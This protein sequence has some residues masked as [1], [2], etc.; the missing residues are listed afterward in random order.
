MNPNT[1]FLSN[2]KN[3]WILTWLLL[4]TFSRLLPH[5]P[6]FT[7]VL[8]IALFCGVEIANKKIALMIPLIIMLI[9]DLYTW[10]SQILPQS[11]SDLFQKMLGINF[12]V[13]GS[14]TLINFIGARISKTRTIASLFIATLISSI[15]FFV[16]TNLAS[17]I[18]F[19]PWTGEGLILCFTNA[20]PYYQNT[21]LSTLLYSGVF[22]G[23]LSWVES[24][25]SP[26]W[27]IHSTA[28]RI[29]NQIGSTK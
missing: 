6:N 28:I 18:A 9:G 21:L 8:A 12:A 26:G 23:G 10:G 17:W 19:Y 7:P 24:R 22:F 13:Y 14:L 20:I 5:P 2:P 15:L 29:R 3:Q 16:L 25:I 11:N 4:G 1:S 27:L